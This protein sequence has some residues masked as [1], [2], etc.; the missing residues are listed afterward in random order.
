M[1]MDDDDFMGEIEFD[2][3]PEQEV[4]VSRAISLAADSDDAFSNINPLIAILQWWQVNVDDNDKVQGSPE[5]I[6]TDACRLFVLAHE[7]QPS[8]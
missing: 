8:R 5:V 2:L 3:S 6:L 1:D 7:P 4:I